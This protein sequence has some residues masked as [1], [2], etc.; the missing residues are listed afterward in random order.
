MK[1][2]AVFKTHVD[3]GFT[4]LPNKVL[5]KYSSTLLTQIVEACEKRRHSPLPLVWTMPAFVLHYVLRNCTNELKKRAEALIKENLLVWHALPFT[6]KT[7]FFS[8]FELRETLYYASELCR[9]YKKPMPISAKMTDVPGHTQALVDVLCEN[10]VKFLHLGCNPASTPPAVPRL[11]FWESKSGNRILTYY[12]KDYGGNVIPPKDWNYPI[13]LSMNVSGDNCGV[14]EDGTIEKLEESLKSYDPTA[15]LCIGTMDD[16][17]KELL[18]CDLSAVPVI[19]GELGDTWIAGLGAFP[20]GC[21]AIGDVRKDFEKISLFLAEKGDTEFAQLQREYLE[22]A[23]LFGEHSGGVDVK[24]LLSERRCYEKDA[25][26][27]ALN[28]EPYLYAKS[29]WDDERSWCYQA[30]D[31][32]L[33]LKKA[34]EKKYGD[35]PSE[36]YQNQT[37]ST[38]FALSLQDG[39]IIVTDQKSQRKIKISYLYEIIGKSTIDSYLDTY[40]TKKYNWALADFGRYKMDGINTYPNVKDQAF[41]LIV[42]KNSQL[43]STIS[44]TYTPDEQSF[45]TYGNAEQITITATIQENR[46]HVSIDLENKQPTMFVEAGYLCFELDEKIEKISICKS[47]VSIDPKTDIVS[48]ANTALFAV[49][50]S[51]TV[52]EITFTPI[53]TPLVCFGEPK[54]YKNNIENFRI[55]KNG[56]VFFNLFN[57][58]WA[59]GSPQWTIGNYHFTFFIDK[60]TD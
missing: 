46:V 2:I 35:I 55:P 13:H 33:Q 49:S 36:K 58:M 25:L 23:L 15:E 5:N 50:P 6:L 10:G 54:I 47:G 21:A 38:D 34:V 3:I 12:D 41:S 57:N 42:K 4:D 8:G 19:R 37:A 56:K 39:Q 16:F 48:G 20:E 52:N 28:S 30:R 1:V 45:K 18:Q 14:H 7:E 24:R 53:H 26:L 9:I 59:S 51:V 11:F 27:K 40:L 32:A 31:A 44:V 17:A 60:Y 43:S 22:N 29:G